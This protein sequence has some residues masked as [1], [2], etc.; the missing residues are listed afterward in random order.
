MFF[1]VEVDLGPGVLTEEELVTLLDVERL[2][3][4]VVADLAIAD[5]DDLALLGLLLG[6]VGNNDPALGLF[7]PATSEVF[8]A[9]SFTI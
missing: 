1:A 7:F 3:L 9:T 5:G 6:G 8:E 2:E 4:S